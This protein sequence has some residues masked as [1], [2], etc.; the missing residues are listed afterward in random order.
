VVRFDGVLY[1][2][3]VID[4]SFSKSSSMLF[5]STAETLFGLTDV[6]HV[7]VLTWNFVNNIGL[8]I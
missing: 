7:T 8:L 4:V 3:A 2:T 6:G 5:Q 1:C